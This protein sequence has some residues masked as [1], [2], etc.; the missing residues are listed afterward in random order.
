MAALSHHIRDTEAPGESE[1]VRD[2]PEL[3][4]YAQAMERGE[5][6]I[7]VKLNVDQPIEL[8]EFLG[9]FTAVAA[10][11]DRYLREKNPQSNG[12]AEMFVKEVRSGSIIADLIPQA[13]HALNQ[14]MTA[15]N[16]VAEFVEHYGWMLAFYLKPG[17]RAPDVSKSRLTDF[18]EQVAAIASNPGSSLEMAAIKIVNGEETIT[19]AF[20]FDTS[21][22]RE[23]QDRVEE[24]KRELDHATRADHERVLMTFVRSDIRDAAVGK[25]SGELVEI[26]AI[27]D[28]PR[29]LI[30]ASAVSEQQIKHEITDAESVYKKGFVVD[31]NVQFNRGK[32][33]AYAVTNLH[34]VIDLP[35]DED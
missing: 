25:R 4:P 7:R 10:E 13:A 30:Y 31:V 34:Q 35:D 1:V 11:Y 3:S 17:G 16:T 32:P 21:Q 15:A 23:I 26:A 2:N 29:P 9:A 14:A 24:H 12:R 22:A 6:F 5:P 18:G 20:K 8:T 19:A 27:S 33:V 28:K